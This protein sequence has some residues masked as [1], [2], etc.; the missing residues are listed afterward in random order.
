MIHK[1]HAQKT[2][3]TITKQE[4]IVN[5]NDYLEE[6]SPCTAQVSKAK[7]ITQYATTVS[8]YKFTAGSICD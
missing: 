7:H 2:K 5:A 8:D 6:L 3:H 4:S 1:Q